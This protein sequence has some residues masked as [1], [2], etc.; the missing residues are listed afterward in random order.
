MNSYVLEE[1]IAMKKGIPPHKRKVIYT[2]LKRRAK[3]FERLHQERKVEK[4]DDVF[5]ILAEAHRQNL[6]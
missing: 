2:D 6:L 1:K 5:N 3:I 4:F